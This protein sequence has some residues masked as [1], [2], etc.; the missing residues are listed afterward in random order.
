M[1]KG[2][3]NK[4]SNK[5][6]TKGSKNKIIISSAESCTGGLI[7]SAL[8]SV[9]GSS[10]VFDRGFITY[11]N[12]AKSELLKIDIDL[13]NKHGAVSKEIAILMAEGSIKNSNANI[14]ISVTGI[15]G[16]GGGTKDKPVGLVHMA[17]AVKN[18]K[19]LD[20]VFSFGAKDRETI[21]ELTTLNALKNL[22]NNI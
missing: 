20:F 22:Y 14:A 11:S 19:T 2:E 10:K 13:I 3:I 15:A 8:T 12:Q 21:R 17:L 9:P 7:S 5:I 6:I 18:R 4:L 16:P 1:N